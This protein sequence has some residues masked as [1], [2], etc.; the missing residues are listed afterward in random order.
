MRGTETTRFVRPN[1][2]LAAITSAWEATRVS[3][4][5]VRFSVS[6]VIVAGRA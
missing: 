2:A 1:S 6:S 3:A 4:S 5:M